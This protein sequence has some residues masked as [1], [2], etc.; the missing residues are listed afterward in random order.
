MN[1]KIKQN[2]MKLIYLKHW[3]SI[4]QFMEKTLKIYSYLFTFLYFVFSY[5]KDDICF[6][7]VFFFLLIL[8]F[9]FDLFC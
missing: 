5:Y 9:A 3:L 4:G 6:V 8:N 7:F 1:E 2:Q